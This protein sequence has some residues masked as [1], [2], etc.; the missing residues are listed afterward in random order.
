MDAPVE[1]LSAEWEKR[2]LEICDGDPI[3]VTWIVMTKNLL[4]SQRNQIREK[5]EG[6][7]KMGGE[8]GF[9]EHCKF[10]KG[11][12]EHDFGECAKHDKILD[13]ILSQL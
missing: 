13:E 12:Y 11:D 2:V 9:C 10:H 1:P 7:R 8:F 6:M 5:I 3:A 4:Q